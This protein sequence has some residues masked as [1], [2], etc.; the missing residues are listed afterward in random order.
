MHEAKPS[1]TA[2]RARPLIAIQMTRHDIRASLYAPLRMIVYEVEGH[3]VHAEYDLP[4]SLFGQF[5]NAEVTN[6]AKRLDLK[7][8]NAIAKAKVG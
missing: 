6:V 1:R 4:S 5:N 3:A 8:E 2:R 7:L